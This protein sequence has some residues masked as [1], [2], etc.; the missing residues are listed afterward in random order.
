M[1]VE[2]ENLVW[3]DTPCLISNVI[4]SFIRTL[5][6][7]QSQDLEMLSYMHWVQVAE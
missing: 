2:V 7:Q 4:I 6:L 5:V 3:N 1:I